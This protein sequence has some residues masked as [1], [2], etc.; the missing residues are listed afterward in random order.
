MTKECLECGTKLVGRVDKKYCSDHCRNAY[1]NKLNKDSKNLVR[2]I[3]NKL[4]KNY[5][6][7][8]SFSLKEGKTTTTKMKLMDKGFDF[9]FITNLYT[10]KKGSTYYFLYDLGYLPLDND[11][12]MIVKRE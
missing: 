8:N 4:R 12:Y 2:N 7:L 5:R 11:R 6:I 3:N 1:N 10:T 9:D